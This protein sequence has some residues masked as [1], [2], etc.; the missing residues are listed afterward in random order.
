MLNIPEV[1]LF[2]VNKRFRAAAFENAL[3]EKDE[4]I[5]DLQHE[6]DDLR[7]AKLETPGDA[8]HTEVAQLNAKIQGLE[9]KLHESEK[10]LDEAPKTDEIKVNELENAVKDKDELIGSLRNE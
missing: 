7:T 6:L 1:F 2:F 4:R 10:A 5:G 8:V 3:R 9:E